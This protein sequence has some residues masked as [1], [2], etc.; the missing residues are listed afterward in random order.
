MPRPRFTQSDLMDLLVATAGLPAA[1]RSMDPTATLTDVGLDSLAFLQLQS[2]LSQRY[3]IELP[4]D[5]AA[6]TFGDIVASVAGHTG[7]QE[8]A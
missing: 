5:L 6:C 1:D 3:G 7:A 8:V 4:D 2:E